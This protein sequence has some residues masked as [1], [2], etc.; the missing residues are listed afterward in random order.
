LRAFTVVAARPSTWAARTTKTAAA[1]SWGALTSE[2]FGHLRHFVP[3]QFPILV[4]IK[5][6]RTLDELFW[7]PATASTTRPF[8]TRA[9]A[10]L[11]A[12]SRA[13]TATGTGSAW[14]TNR[15]EFCVGQLAVIIL[16]E[17]L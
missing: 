2:L 15:S 7:V 1:T 14:T 6:H 12:T 13:N 5:G 4:G 10:T 16:V 9:T 3:T 8:T 11:L 17:F